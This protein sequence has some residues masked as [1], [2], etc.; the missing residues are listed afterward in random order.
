MR[1]A[2]YARYSS[3]LQRPTSI[4][5]QLALCRQY[6]ARIGAIVDEAF[7]FI[8]VEISAAIAQRPGYQRFL[9]AARRGDFEAIIVE[10]QDRLWRSQAEMHRALDELRFHEVLV[11]CVD[12]G[13]ELTG[14]SGHLLASFKGIMDE[15]YRQVLRDKTRRG[16]AGQ[17]QRG[18]SPGGRPYGYRS[19]PVAGGGSRR[20]V[21]PGEAAVVRR[22]FEMYAAGHSPKAI[23]KQLNAEGVPAPWSRPRGWAPASINGQR[24]LALGILNNPICVGRQ[25]WNRTRKLWDPYT[26]RRVWR[27]VPREQWVITEV[28][29][30][31]IIPDGLW[32]A[33]QARRDALGHRWSRGCA[34]PRYLLSGLIVCAAC[35]SAYSIVGGSGKYGCT[36]HYNRGICS[37]RALVKRAMLED[38]ILGLVR[39][40]MLAPPVLA[41]LVRRVERKVRQ[42]LARP[43]E[44]P[45]PLSAAEAEVGRL[46]EAIRHGRG[47]IPELVRLLEEARARV[48]ALRAQRAERPVDLHVLP[49]L[50]RQY[51]ENLR[52]LVATD[53]AGARELLRRVVAPVRVEP[54]EGGAVLVV[55]GNLAGIL[56][57][58][59]GGAGGPT[60]PIETRTFEFPLP[61]RTAALRSARVVQA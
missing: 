61:S 31:R 50:A 41:A 30:L 21:H 4:E 45:A 47:E 37:N 2:L 24:Q 35:G 29:E 49:E 32:Q 12:T 33:V 22:I 6:A 43:A 15:D 55:R 3:A 28:P 27:R 19:E 10:A 11:F 54:R 46:L 44:D 40:R 60:Y 56:P 39:D 53:V 26:G 48:A 58:G 52:S 25:V 14:R 42:H 7:I 59:L 9:A 5:D 16:M 23:A 17:V 13:I 34:P 36:G 38:W 8:D 51:L 20:V 57:V 18:F 1:T